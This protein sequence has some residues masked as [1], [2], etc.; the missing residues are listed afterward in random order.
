MTESMRRSSG[1]I[2]A[3]LVALAA[4]ALAG[5][6]QA[7]ASPSLLPPGAIAPSDAQRA[8][9]RKIGRILEEAHYSHAPIDRRMSELVFQRYLEFLDPQRSYLLAS[10]IA[11]FSA[12]RDQFDDMIRTGGIEPAYLMF[13]RFQQRNRERMQ[14]ALAQLK[15]EPDWTVSETFDFER[16]DAPW[17]A[18]Q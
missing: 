1:W 8:T 4:L 13:A 3:C 17:P 11:E 10:D 12:Y 14:F 15:T 18:D 7:P 5:S 6:V 16:K 2:T 9:A